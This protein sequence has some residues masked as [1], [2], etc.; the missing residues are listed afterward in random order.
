MWLGRESCR[1]VGG[2]EG[3]CVA[4]VS[5][6]ELRGMKQEG[7]GLCTYTR[8]M[9]DAPFGAPLRGRDTDRLRREGHPAV[10]LGSR[11]I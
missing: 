6:L 4:Q 1:Q 5:R 9:D 10:R 7:R 2:M 8:S 11:R 3:L